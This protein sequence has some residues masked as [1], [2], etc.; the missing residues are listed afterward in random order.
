[1][2]H[3][4]AHGQAPRLYPLPNRPITSAELADFGLAPSTIRAARQRGDLPG[5]R[6]GRKYIFDPNTV[7]DF[8]NAQAE[9]NGGDLRF[10]VV[11]A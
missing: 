9:R 5:A 6:I 2:T 1:M 11:S 4:S 3:T 8:L 7:A 10:A